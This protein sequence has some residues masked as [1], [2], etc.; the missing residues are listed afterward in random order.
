[1]TKVESLRRRNLILGVVAVALLAFVVLRPSETSAVATEAYPALFPDLE[2]A[3]ART[4]VLR[5]VPKTGAEAA[6]EEMRL[7]RADETSWVLATSF[8]YPASTEKVQRFLEDLQGARRKKVVTERAETFDEYAATDGWVHVEVTG[9][10]GKVL[11]SADLGKSAG[12]PDGFVRMDQDEKPVVVRAYNLSATDARLAA[13]AWTE[14]ALW[15]GLTLP[16]V[17][18]I[19]V[20]QRREKQVL[21]F[22]RQERPVEKPEGEEAAGGAEPATESVWVMRAPKQ[23]DPEIFRVE[24]LVRTFTGM[25]FSKIVGNEPGDAADQHYG[26]DEPA[27]RVVV[28]TRPPEGADEGPKYVLLVG[29]EVPPEK[30]GATPD[31]WYVR[32]EGDDWVFAVRAVSIGDFKQ[33]P[34][35]YL[36]KAEEPEAPEEPAGEPGEAP[37]PEDRGTGSPDAEAPGEETPPPPPGGDPNAPPMPPEPPDDGGDDGEG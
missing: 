13:D 29:R 26:L 19:D 27:Y 8:G 5:R 24:G 33:A 31:A 22:V 7:Q 25:R 28:H 9:A 3:Q 36:P 6:P 23:A 30:E 34:D 18:M 2:V 11:A 35:D 17:Q 12:W 21:S 15:P 1:M 4:V 37:P 14:A 32:R 16:D 20:H 10:A